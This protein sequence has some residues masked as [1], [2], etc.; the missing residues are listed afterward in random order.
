MAP[1]AVAICE[2]SLARRA[3]RRLLRAAKTLPVARLSSESRRSKISWALLE[4]ANDPPE[5][6]STRRVA[7]ALVRRAA[8]LSAVRSRSYGGG[9]VLIAAEHVPALHGGVADGDHLL[10]ERLH[11]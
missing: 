4:T 1:L 10:E 3:L 2:T 11:F 9:A 5:A 7:A 8:P 6:S